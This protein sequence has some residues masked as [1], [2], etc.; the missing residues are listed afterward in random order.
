MIKHTPGP[1]IIQD[2]RIGPL[3]KEPDQSYGMLLPV[4]YIEQYD[5]PNHKSNAAL[6]AAA[7]ELLEALE[8]FIAWVDKQNLEYES[9]MV[10]QAKAAIAKAKGEV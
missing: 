4:A 7:P 9:A 2:Y 5:Y 8:R 6:I 3:L 1:W 10:R